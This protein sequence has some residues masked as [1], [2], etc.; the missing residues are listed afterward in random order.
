MEKTEQ[1]EDIKKIG[2]PIDNYK[3]ETFKREFDKRGIKYTIEDYNGATKI[4]KTEVANKDVAD[5]GEVIK[6]I[7]HLAQAEKV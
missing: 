4:I 3:E 6:T 1:P 2:I 7:N 5:F